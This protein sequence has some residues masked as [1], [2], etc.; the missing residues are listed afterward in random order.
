MSALRQQALAIVESCK[1]VIA[2]SG[3]LPEVDSTTY[4]TAQDI[5]RRAQAECPNDKTLAAVKL[6]DPKTWTGV[7]T[8]MELVAA[9]V[10][11]P[12]VAFASRRG[13]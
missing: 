10:P 9:S 1:A 7:L 12:A 4:F 2:R 11:P 3:E 6:K 8:T 13:L 5:L